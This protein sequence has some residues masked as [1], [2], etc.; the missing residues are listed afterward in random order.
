MKIK[1]IYIL[2][3]ASFIFLYFT[4]P[5]LIPKYLSKEII[6][7]IKENVPNIFVPKDVDIKLLFSGDIFFDRHI[8]EKSQASLL[9][10]SYP[11]QGL[12]TLDRDSYDAWIGNLECP[13]TVEQSTSY[14]KA[15]WLRFS[16]KK[17]YLPELKKYFDIVS[18]ANNHTDNMNQRKGIEETRTHLT[19]SG[20]KYFGDYDSSVSDEICRVYTINNIPIAFCGFHGAY[21]LPTD[22]ELSIIK[23]Y[24][25]YF[26]T[27]V[28]PHQGEEYKFKSNSY[29]KKIYRTMID[30]GA[31]VVIG[32][33]PHVIQEV[34]EYK[35]K[36]IFY[37]LGNFIFDQSWSKTREH[38]V[39][40]MEIKI[41]EYKD[42]YKN[43]DCENL[44][45][46]ECL[47]KAV[48]LSTE[49][50][51]FILT[52]KP[53]FTSSGLDFIT[54]KSDI[55]EETYQKLLKG[56]GFDRVASSSKSD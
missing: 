55:S 7:E 4:M 6:S 3:F 50:P 56:I 42:N 34:E 2:I 41:K 52:Y 51:E 1:P 17:E 19:E 32:S 40:D 53:I 43:I 15:N 10:Y 33:H 25:K 35:G 9:K 48:N 37:S 36:L 5:I 47:K 14:E 30:N 16:C 12:S 18:L 27:V 8:D 29:Q 22:K 44:N 39:V 26:L 21:K 38:M 23:D 11:F 20:I 31:D 49:K 13:V 46:P 28:M 45:G 54:K 24:S